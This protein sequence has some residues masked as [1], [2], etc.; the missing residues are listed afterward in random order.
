MNI[1]FFDIVSK[2]TQISNFVKIRPVGAELFLADRQT[3][4]TKPV[5]AF[6]NSAHEPNRKHRL[7]DEL[8]LYVRN[9]IVAGAS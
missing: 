7:L 8:K 5:F 9:F 1:D 3:G 6:R 2:N 4:M